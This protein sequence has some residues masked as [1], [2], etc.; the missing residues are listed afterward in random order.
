M[1]GVGNVTIQK[2][3]KTAFYYV[4]SIKDLNEIIIPHFDKYPLISQKRADFILFKSAV[5]LINKKDHLTQKGLMK[6]VE[7]RASMN[8]GLTSTLKEH[9]PNLTPVLKP[10]IKD[11][12]IP[13][14]NWLVGFVN[15]EGCFFIDIYKSST[16]KLGQAVK[17]SFIITQH[18]KDAQLIQSLVQYLGHGKFYINSNQTA[19]YFKITKFEDLNEKVIP[20]FKKYSE[21]NLWILRTDVKLL[22]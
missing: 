3:K 1:G 20:L 10:E 15:G 17:L 9:F 14:P 7:I 8:W 22:L 19:V 21:L 16:T 6:I 4:S 18:Y 13:D 11:Q 2:N 12:K 5:E